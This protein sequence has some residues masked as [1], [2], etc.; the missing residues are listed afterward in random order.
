[1]SPDPPRLPEWRDLSDDEMLAH[2]AGIAA[3]AGRVDSTLRA[4][5]S[6][7]RTRGVTWTRIGDTLGVSRQSAWE[8]FSGDD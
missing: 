3:T 1:V 2:T 6:E 8:R 5:V 7:L 4:W